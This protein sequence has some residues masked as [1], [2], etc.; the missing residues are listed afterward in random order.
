MMR[1]KAGCRSLLL[2]LLLVS[3]GAAGQ[4]YPGKAVRYIVPF[5]P[6]GGQDLVARAVAQRLTEFL[7]QQVLVDNRPGG[8]ATLGAELAARAAPDGY[9]IFMGSNTTH[10]INPNLYR[11]LSYDPIKDF[12]AITQIASLPNIL[13]VHPSLPVRSVKE[14]AA[15]ARAR[16]GELNFGSS[17]NGTPA[18][19]SGVMFNQAARVNMVH[20]PYKGSGPALIALLSGETH[21]MFGSI[22]ST[23]SYVKGGRLR[24]LA[25]TSAK[26]SPAVA[27]MPTIA[28]SGYPGFE[29]VTWYGLFVPAGTPSAVVAKLNAEMV[30]L[31]NVPE[32][33]Q[34]LM[35]QG[36]EPVG[37]TP[38]EFA[39]FVKAEL[40]KYVGI[41]KASGLRPD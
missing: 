14:L 33:K 38:Q 20:V 30:R 15:L 39:A 21:L 26:R 17:G 23:L 41:V 19:L 13:V 40:E 28:E 2:A 11:K 32:F 18:Q 1:G 3:G 8:G 25:V 29:A 4:A 27:E 10:A 37:N 12:I 6:G 31:L 36:A 9:T 22:T 16:P 34:W 7:G 35:G 24:A 5:P